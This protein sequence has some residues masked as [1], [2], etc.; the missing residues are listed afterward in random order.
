LPIKDRDLSSAAFNQTVTF[1]LAS[2]NRDSWSLDTQHLG[3]QT[4]SDELCVTFTAI[5]HHEQPTRKS[6]LEVVRTVAR[7]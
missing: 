1:Q 3:K 5:A 4:L 6:L 2:S 7:Y